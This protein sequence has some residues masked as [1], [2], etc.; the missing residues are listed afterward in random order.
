MLPCEQVKLPNNPLYKK[1]A[2]LWQ[3]YEDATENK[4]NA[5]SPRVRD[6][7]RTLAQGAYQAN[8]QWVILGRLGQ[9][10][11]LPGMDDA[12]AQT[13]GRVALVLGPWHAPSAERL[14]TFCRVPVSTH[15][16]P[17]RYTHLEPYGTAYVKMLAL[18]R[19]SHRDLS[20][21]MPY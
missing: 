10:L 12:L 13:N 6:M 7:V 8:R 17:Q 14:Q 5:L 9:W 16:V 2:E 15:K 19:I 1:M 4:G 21:T 11:R 20:I 3:L 18:G